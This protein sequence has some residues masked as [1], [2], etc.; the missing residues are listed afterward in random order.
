[1]FQNKIKIILSLYCINVRFY[2]YNEQCI[3]KLCLIHKYRTYNAERILRTYKQSHKFFGERKELVSQLCFK[4]ALKYICRVKHP[5][6]I[7]AL[8]S[9]SYTCPGAYFVFEKQKGRTRTTLRDDVGYAVRNKSNRVFQE[10]RE[11]SVHEW[12]NEN[13]CAIQSDNIPRDQR[14]GTRAF[15]LY[16]DGD[17]ATTNRCR[18]TH[19]FSQVRIRS[20]LSYSH[21]LHTCIHS[22]SKKKWSK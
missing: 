3:F 1:M 12:Y 6:K 10:G 8:R 13:R 20:H 9:V 22:K 11:P 15:H 16:E 2:F 5:D 21:C 19:R 4:T 7:Y 14:R 17:T 18:K